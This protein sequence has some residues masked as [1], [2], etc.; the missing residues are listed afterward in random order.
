MLPSSG[1]NDSVVEPPI[2]KKAKTSDANNI[3]DDKLV[4]E[5]TKNPKRTN[6]SPM[7][8]SPVKLPP[9]LENAKLE[10]VEL[11]VVQS[12]TT[13]LSITVAKCVAGVDL[14][15]PS[16][17]QLRMLCSKWKMK[18]YRSAKK[19]VI[20]ELIATHQKMRKYYHDSE[21]KQR[22]N[23]EELQGSR[24]R[25]LNVVFSEDFFE[26]IVTMNDRKLR[27]ELDAGGAGGNRSRWAEL[28]ES[29][30]DSLNNDSYGSYA[31]IEDPHVEEFV[32]TYD[33][34]TFRQLDSEKAGV[35]FKEIVKDYTKAMKNYTV[36][37]THQPDFYGFV[38]NK[39]Q[40]YYY[41]LYILANPECHKAFSLLLDDSI[42]SESTDSNGGGANS[43]GGK[44]TPKNK[45]TK[46]NNEKKEEI[47]KEVAASMTAA[48]SAV[49][50]RSVKQTEKSRLEQITGTIMMNLLSVPD[51][52]KG[53]R[54]RAFFDKQ[55][56]ENDGRVEELKQ[57]FVENPSPQK[58]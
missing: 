40:T 13:G 50:T 47:L 44:K 9:M 5:V 37:G 57:W 3:D 17:T 1:D 43:N 31:F 26:S 35:W 33:L 30:N 28:T 34:C 16:V 29:Y 45:G 55:I 58:K 14:D 49:Q 48:Y 32:S 38:D 56:T 42:F 27:P 12:K 41:R 6:Q 54:A 10:D 39:P 8:P 4:A 15:K 7:K 18:K 19:E 22:L 24:M 21:Q 23:K 36:S 25:L 53:D 46:T 20:L 51:G 11:H 2:A 52:D